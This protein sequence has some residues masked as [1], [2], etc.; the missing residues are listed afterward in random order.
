V[1]GRAS[2]PVRLSGN[3][4]VIWA[5]RKRG[6]SL[7]DRLLTPLLA[8]YRPQACYSEAEVQMLY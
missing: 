4:E 1:E 3:S 6:L 5:A 2:S 8:E 7:C